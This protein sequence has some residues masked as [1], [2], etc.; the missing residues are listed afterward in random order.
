[1]KANIISNDIAKAMINMTGFRNVVIHEYQEMDIDILRSIADKE[2]KY[3]IEFCRELG[4]N[5]VV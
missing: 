4:A 5:I 3:L 2:Y 1:M